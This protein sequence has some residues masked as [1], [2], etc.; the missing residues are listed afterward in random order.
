MAPNVERMSPSVAL[1][2][3]VISHCTQVCFDEVIVSGTFCLALW[4]IPLFAQ[5]SGDCDVY[6]FIKGRK[7]LDEALS[8]FQS[9]SDVT[10]AVFFFLRGG[11]GLAASSS[12]LLSVLESESA[13][14][15]FTLEAAAFCEEEELALLAF[16][17]RVPLDDELL[18]GG[19][20]ALISSASSAKAKR[21]LYF[22]FC[23]SVDVA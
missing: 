12:S 22:V 7:D 16:P 14:T 9:L 13:R 5:L 17:P 1:T 8:M 4:H 3:S 18:E 10:R 15:G 19:G 2:I 20:G 11:L 6:I 21:S 23:A